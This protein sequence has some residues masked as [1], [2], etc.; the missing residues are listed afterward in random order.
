MMKLMQILQDIAENLHQVD[1]YSLMCDET[2][3]ISNT[4]QLVICLHWVDDELNAH[5]EF[6]GLKDMSSTGTDAES[7]VRVERCSIVY[8]PETKQMLWPL[9]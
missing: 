9:L 5:N 1:F 4:S 8:E 6:I 2:T 7:I 3:D